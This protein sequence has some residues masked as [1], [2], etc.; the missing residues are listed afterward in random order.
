MSKKLKLTKI[1][2][3]AMVSLRGGCDSYVTP[4]CGCGCLYAGE[5]NGSS[6][7]ANGKANAG[8]GL[9]SPEER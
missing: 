8:S 9:H 1:Q 4:N 6:C 3:K 7:E 5:P 2:K